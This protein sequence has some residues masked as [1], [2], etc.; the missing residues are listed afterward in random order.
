MTTSGTIGVTSI[1]TDKLITHA[2]RRCG[3]SP[4]SIT[5]E[6]I[7][8]A[9]ENL[10]LI[11]LSLA[12]VGIS[13]WLLEERLIGF[14]PNQVTYV[15]PDGTTD[16]HNVQVITPQFTSG[17]E[18]IGVNSFTIELENETKIVA[19]SFNI[20]STIANNSL[21]LEY[22]DD[23]LSWTTFNS[24]DISDLELD[25]NHWFY[26][27]PQ[28]TA[29]F[30]RL[31]SVNN[32]TLNNFRLVV[33]VS[34]IPIFPYNRDDYYSLSNRDFTSSL[35]TNFYYEKYLNPQIKSWPIPNTADKFWSF[36][37]QRQ[38]QDVGYMTQSVEVPERFKEYLI[39]ELAKRLC[40][41]IPGIAADRV[42]S[43][44]NEAAM[45]AVAVNIGE[46]DGTPTRIQ[47]QIQP[48][49]R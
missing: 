46:T 18:T 8:I 36:V 12:N 31:T 23:G 49:T 6:T 9:K 45:H 40:Y 39:W 25:I 37:I 3:L 7:E 17:D 32:F 1:D 20:D 27:D 4:S 41:E 5:A 22:S 42:Q 2:V 14:V 19:F 38:I 43:I 29:T 21:D 24:Y 16:L 44:S 35:P 48:Y 15:L 10:Y 47:M 28:I 30:F 34:S 13:L 33:S 26:L 11:L